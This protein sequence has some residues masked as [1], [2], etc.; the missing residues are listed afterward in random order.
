M[1]QRILLGPSFNRKAASLFQGSGFYHA[2]FKLGLELVADTDAE[3]VG[4]GMGGAAGEDALI[5]VGIIRGG[6]SVVLLVVVGVHVGE[7]EGPLVPLEAH[8]AGVVLAA[9]G[10]HHVVGIAVVVGGLVEHEAE[11]QSHPFLDPPFGG[12]IEG[13]VVTPMTVGVIPVAGIGLHIHVEVGE[14]APQSIGGTGFN[15]QI[16]HRLISHGE[17]EGV[18]QMDGAAELMFIDHEVRIQAIHSGKTRDTVSHARS[19]RRQHV[20][21][22]GFSLNF[23]AHGGPIGQASRPLFVELGVQGDIAPKGKAVT[24][25]INIAAVGNTL[26]TKS[27]G[28]ILTHLHIGVQDFSADGNGEHVVQ[29]VGDIG[30][31]RAGDELHGLKVEAAGPVL[32]VLHAKAEA[33]ELT[34]AQPHL[35]VPLMG[36]IPGRDG[37]GL[38]GAMVIVVAGTVRDVHAPVHLGDGKVALKLGTFQTGHGSRVVG[39]NGSIA[40]T[41]NKTASE[42]HG[43]GAAF[44][45]GG[46][47]FSI[48]LLS[49]NSKRQREERAQRTKR[50][51]TLTG[52]IHR[53]TPGL[54]LKRRSTASRAMIVR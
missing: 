18:G 12:D 7:I 53:N 54:P 4:M 31:Q 37:P 6:F 24:V 41:G 21:P 50:A 25:D 17:S 16:F 42:G 47:A 33:G 40:T 44:E 2:L 49:G 13:P 51:R 27:G 19:G 8:T 34:D 14:A 20:V 39:D 38:M 1:P 35:V 30:I 46:E 45:T 28:E 22:P 29:L 43:A 48:G 3:V 10:G 11:A 26:R 5:T 32:G 15:T 23:Q 52:K 36:E 9:V